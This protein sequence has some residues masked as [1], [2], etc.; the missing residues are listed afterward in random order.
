MDGAAQFADFKRT[1]SHLSLVAENVNLLGKTYHEHD[2]Q[3]EIMIYGIPEA[4]FEILK[5]KDYLSVTIA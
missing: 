3:A 4:P 2:F 5:A 1:S